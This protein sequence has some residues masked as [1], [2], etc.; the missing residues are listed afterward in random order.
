MGIHW[1][2]DRARKE[3]QK[4]GMDVLIAKDDQNVYY[5][6]GFLR[7]MARAYGVGGR[8]LL[9]IT[10]ADPSSEPVGICSTY[11]MGNPNY[12]GNLV[13][14]CDRFNRRLTEW[15]AEYNFNRPHEALDYLAPIENIERES[16][17]TRG[18]PQVLPMW[19]A[20]TRKM[21]KVFLVKV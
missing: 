6:S 3:M 5:T 9:T 13:L 10:S 7:R 14:D 4:R 17:R 2:L 16:I 8:S 21:R 12:N 18:S 19:S 15:L 20:C 11:E 1:D